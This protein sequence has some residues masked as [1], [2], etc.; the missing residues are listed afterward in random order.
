MADNLELDARTFAAWGVDYLKVDGCYEDAAD[1]DSHY[2]SLSSYLNATGRLLVFS[3]SWPAKAYI[4]PDHGEA[5]N[6]A[7]LNRLSEICHTWPGGT[8]T[9]LR[10]HGTP[11]RA[12]LQQLVE[13]QRQ[14]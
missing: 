4:V 11:F 5:S 13:A 9:T 6:G 2:T 8:S 1:M 7:V 12:L 10:T 14:I 3:C